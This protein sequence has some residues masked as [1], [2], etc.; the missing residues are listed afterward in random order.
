MMGLCPLATVLPCC[1]W[2]SANVSCHVA[3]L[4]NVDNYWMWSEAL[5]AKFL[6]P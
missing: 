5:L 6:K 3:L 2:G 4:L 1:N